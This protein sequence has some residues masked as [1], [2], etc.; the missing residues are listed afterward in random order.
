MTLNTDVQHLSHET[1]HVTP[2]CSKIQTQKRYTNIIELKQPLFLSG[3]V[4]SY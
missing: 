3:I 1:K 2:V 4:P